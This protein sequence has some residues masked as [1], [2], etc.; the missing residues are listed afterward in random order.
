MTQ[1]LSTVDIASQRYEVPTAPIS[2]V[3][4]MSTNYMRKRESTKLL[5]KM[6]AQIIGAIRPIAKGINDHFNSHIVRS[7]SV[8]R[9]RFRKVAINFLRVLS[10]IFFFTFS[11]N[12][13]HL[14]DSILKFK[15]NR[16]FSLF[17]YRN[18]FCLVLSQA[19]P[20]S[21]GL[22]NRKCCTLASL[23]NGRELD[24]TGSYNLVIF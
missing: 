18:L 19:N 24:P 3:I 12:S 7:F 16:T 20:L 9:Y 2:I 21:F 23:T 6:E 10:P 17:T 15:L 4:N 8:L 1:D 11:R 13:L 14:K 22:E 5:I